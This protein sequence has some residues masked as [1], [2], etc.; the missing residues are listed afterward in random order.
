MALV[1]GAIGIPVFWWTR[2][3]I[4]GRRDF[5]K[6]FTPG[7]QLAVL[8]IVLVSVAGIIAW[9]TGKIKL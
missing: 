5:K 1:F 7:E 2:A 3:K 4:E 9:A 6:L 8:V